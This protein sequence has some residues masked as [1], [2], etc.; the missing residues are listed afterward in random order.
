MF[1]K[2]LLIAI[3]AT[4]C[5]GCAG[6][7]NLKENVSRGLYDGLT[8]QY[9]DRD[10]QAMGDRSHQNYRQPVSYDQYN[11]ERKRLLKEENSEQ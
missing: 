6:Q 3:S 9:P 8:T 7:D 10:T 5:F 2:L 11:S 4:L 1:L